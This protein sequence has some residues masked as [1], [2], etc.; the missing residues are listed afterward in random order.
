L[1]GRCRERI[2]RPRAALKSAAHSGLLRLGRP[3]GG[4]RRRD[5]TTPQRARIRPT[6]HLG[7]RVPPLL[8]AGFSQGGGLAVDLAIDADPVTSVGFLAVAAGAEDLAALPDRDRLVA[9]AARGLRGR[10][11]VG[12]R[13]DALA[14]AG[15][16]SGAAVGA[17]LACSL[18]IR[19]GAGHEMPEPPG[20]LL[21]DE[22]IAL[23]ARVGT[24]PA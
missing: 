18:T 12:D 2:S 10:L 16:L 15:A 20:R 23:L 7:R 3:R 19:P 11:L 17:G 4:A 21:V 5:G 1:A 6:S 9:A 8:T 24:E 13:D 14:G 22:L